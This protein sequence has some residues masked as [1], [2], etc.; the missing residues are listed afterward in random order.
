L[1]PKQ[2]FISCVLIFDQHM[3]SSP[4]RSVKDI[5]PVPS[6]TPAAPLENRLRGETTSFDE[7]EDYNNCSTNSRRARSHLSGRIDDPEGDRDGHDCEDQEDSEDDNGLS[8]DVDDFSCYSYDREVASRLKRVPIPKKMK[9][10]D[11]LQKLSTEKADREVARSLNRTENASPRYTMVSHVPL[12]P[13]VHKSP[14]GASPGSGSRKSPGSKSPSKQSASPKLLKRKSSNTKENAGSPFKSEK[15]LESGG[16][17]DDAP[18]YLPELPELNSYLENLLQDVV[19]N[20][21]RLTVEFDDVIKASVSKNAGADV[22]AGVRSGRGLKSGKRNNKQASTKTT[23]QHVNNPG[24][25]SSEASLAA[26][27][28][29]CPKVAVRKHKDE[30][31][32]AFVVSGLPIHDNLPSVAEDGTMKDTQFPKLVKRNNQ[33]EDEQVPNA[34]GKWSTVGLQA[35]LTQGQRTE[36]N[37]KRDRKQFR[38]TNKLQNGQVHHLLR[39][40]LLNCSLTALERQ[41]LEEH[42]TLEVN[43]LHKQ[44]QELRDDLHSQQ[45]ATDEVGIV[46]NLHSNSVHERSHAS[47]TKEERGR[48]ML[49]IQALLTK[50]ILTEFDWLRLEQH[51]ISDVGG[52]HDAPCD[53]HAPAPANASAGAGVSAPAAATS[54]VGTAGHPKWSARQYH[55]RSATMLTTYLSSTPNQIGGHFPHPHQ[56]QSK[57]PKLPNGSPHVPAMPVAGAPS[58]LSPSANK[59]LQVYVQSGTDGPDE[60]RQQQLPSSKHQLRLLKLKKQRAYKDRQKPEDI[61]YSNDGKI[62]ATP[63]ASVFSIRKALD[64]MGVDDDD[65]NS[66]QMS[67]TRQTDYSALESAPVIVDAAAD[68]H[69]T[70]AVPV[71]EVNIEEV[72]ISA[73]QQLDNPAASVNSRNKNNVAVNSSPG[74]V[75]TAV[76]AAGSSSVSEIPPQADQGAVVH[77]VQPPEGVP[78]QSRSVKESIAGRFLRMFSTKM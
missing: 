51:V 28:R 23:Q 66:L 27:A 33:L 54:A 52:D 20:C 24:C 4:S 14:L 9:L 73:R 37:M 8:F 41:E 31:A 39:S 19:S 12:M 75:N 70:K 55:H 65:K 35:Y 2:F 5:G 7:F 22:S 53:S 43:E 58:T 13:P 26:R 45:P 63:T 78:P 71:G 57:G 62:A 29:L 11:L 30:I 59:L 76:S 38:M 48:S 72:D 67:Y 6:R 56:P 69:D 3:A 36:E 21:N 60:K 77:A 32:A 34:R 46:N 61:T 49:W 18:I 15:G 44:Q 25:L 10:S 42:R 74:E 1:C 68:V 47:S 40:L 16:H 17:A 50:R 64:E